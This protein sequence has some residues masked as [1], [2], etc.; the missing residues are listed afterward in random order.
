MTD[1]T[2]DVDPAALEAELDEIKGAIGLAED[3][4]YW[5]RFW[6]V[7]GVGAGLCF[8][9]VQ[10]WFRGGPQLPILAAFISLLGLETL[11]KRRIRAAYEPPTAGL[12]DQRLWL[13]AVLAAIGALLVGLLPVFDALGERNAVRLALVSAGAVVGAGYVYMGQLLGAYDIRAADRY[14][15]YAGGAWILVLAAA[16]PH[17]PAAEGWEYAVFGL[18]IAVQHV[19]AYVVL[20]RR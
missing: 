11:V 12:P 3:H 8:T 14:A 6:L 17:V 5:W 2:E 20:S 7:E 10:F 19:A 18:G 9:L 1:G 13:L 16:I 15:F 4:P